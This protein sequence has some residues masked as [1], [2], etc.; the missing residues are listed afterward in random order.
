MAMT[1]LPS[2]VPYAV[3]GPIPMPE[4]AF[5]GAG[6]EPDVLI[7]RR[8]ESS[9]LENLFAE[10]PPDGG[11]VLVLRGEPGIGKT[12]LLEHAVRSAPGWRVVRTAGVESEADLAY[13]ALQQLCSS[14]LHRLER[15][16][17]PQRD[18]LS[19][20]FGLTSEPGAER[21]LVGLATLNLFSK[22]ADEQ[23]VICVV[24]DAQWLDRESAQTLAFVA[25]R[26]VNEPIAMLFA[27][28]EGRDELFGLPEL[29]IKGLPE[30]DAAELLS[31]VVSAAV[32]PSVRNR[33]IAETRGNPLALLELPRG[34]TPAELAVG[35]GARV[36][37]SLSR[38]IEE[39]FGRR[40]SGLPLDTQRLLLVAA[41][42]H[43]GDAAKVRRAAEILGISKEA[44]GPADDAALLDI[45]TAVRFRHPLVRS[46]AYR[47]ASHRERQLVHQ[48]L[49]I[50]TDP[51]V[52]PDRH[53][54]HMAAA[55]AWPDEAVAK[56]LEW[57]AGR[58]HRARWICRRRSSS[59]A[60]SRA[61]PR[62]ERTG[63]QAAPGVRGLFA[64]RGY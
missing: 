42:D 34:L 7:G 43:L 44:A 25:R 36:E 50:A 27:T 45:G 57:S 56:E 22:M 17:R 12:D 28:R 52:D 20:A 26:L 53:A 8:Q 33:I 59:G 6:R 55:T 24:D 4:A 19:V 64:S 5:A 1:T 18:A 21:F 29:L 31:S 30:E 23:P 47:L 41:A 58:A 10:G 54:W 16:P 11:R 3:D 9:Q 15:L 13:A 48:A 39:T 38:R 14:S 61:H 35:F 46:A 62:G 40:I 49:A 32:S 37:M 2:V 63:G 60:L 51:A